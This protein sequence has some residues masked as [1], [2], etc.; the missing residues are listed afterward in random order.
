M[1]TTSTCAAGPH[2][3]NDGTSE[4]VTLGGEVHF[5]LRGHR[6]LERMEK[7]HFVKS[8]AWLTGFAAGPA[9]EGSSDGKMKGLHPASFMKC[10]P[11]WTSA[12][13][14]AKNLFGQKHLGVAR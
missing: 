3:T 4:V 1:K 7:K 8:G 5:G 13:V 2:G 6:G 11:C 9:H 14:S 12:W 10:P